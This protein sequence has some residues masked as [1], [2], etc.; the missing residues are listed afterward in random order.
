M[1]HA[2]EWTG[3]NTYIFLWRKDSMGIES[4]LFSTFLY[5]YKGWFV[6]S[7]LKVK[8]FIFGDTW[9][10]K[11]PYISNFSIIVGQVFYLEENYTLDGARSGGEKHGCCS[12]G[13]NSRR[14]KHLYDLKL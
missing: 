4:Y 5:S 14:N 13:V 8:P 12:V 3:L 10:L 2:H 7:W 6:L 9:R 1:Q 11:G